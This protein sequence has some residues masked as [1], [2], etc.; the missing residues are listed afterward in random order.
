MIDQGGVGLVPDGGDE[1]D[2]ALGRGAHDFLLVERPQIFDRTAAARD[3][4][5]V[6]P[7]LDRRESTNRR[8]DFARSAL[9]LDRDRPQDHAS[10]TPVLQ[11]VENVADHRP[12]RR[13]DD[14]DH[15][16][17]EGQLA[18]AAGVEQSFGGE[19]L[20]ALLEQSEQRPLPRKLHPLDDDLVLGAPRISRQ[21]PRSDDLGAIFGTKRETGRTRAPDDGVDAGILVLQREIAVAGSVPLE[22]TNLSPHAHLAE[23]ALDRSLERAGK[24]G[25]RERRRIVPGSDVR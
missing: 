23:R 14:A 19:R 4:Q 13:G 8:G 18:L 1:R 16:R 10:R 3:D 11:A 25:D 20:A 9:A 5:Q 17:E 22:P 21:L 2:R 12:R 6:W 7:R 15:A 24:L